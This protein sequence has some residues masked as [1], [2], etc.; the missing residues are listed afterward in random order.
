MRH[1][2][3]VVLACIPML[4]PAMF[5]TA[6]AQQQPATPLRPVDKARLQQQPPVETTQKINGGE[7]AAPGQYPFQ[8]A[9]IWSGTPEGREQF[10]QFCGG[11]LIDRSWVVTAAHCVPATGPEEVDVYVGSVVLPSGTGGAAGGTRLHLSRIISHQDYVEATHDN[12]VAMVKLAQPAPAN[13]TPAIVASP[14]IENA[15]GAIGKKVTV[16]GW[17]A[18]S[19]GGNTTPKLMQ[20]TVT[21]QDRLQCEAN[22]RALVPAATITGNMFCAG[23]LAGLK[24]SCQGDSGGFIGAPRAGG[25]FNQLGVVSWGIGCARPG[26]F[27]VYTRLAQ[28]E[29]WVRD[30]IKNF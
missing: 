21:V 28:Y 30:V 13:L 18:T 26:L 12:D 19:E 15:Q 14:A 1:V 5:T 25:G 16:I 2:R 3:I 23:E 7:P 29:T 6:S 4:V 10:G 8:V 11:A 22:Y 17:G 27:G 24:D 20:V 9:L